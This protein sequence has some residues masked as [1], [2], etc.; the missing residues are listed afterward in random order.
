M[1]LLS[2]TIQGTAPLLCN[3]FH[4]AAQMSATGDSSRISTIGDRGTPLDQAQLKLYLSESGDPHIP[5]PNVFR[6]LIEAGKFFKSGKSKLTT[7]K[8]SLIPACVNILDIEIPLQHKQPWTVD[9]R[10]VRIP[11]TGGRILA[12]RPCFHDWTL[13]FTIELDVDLM[14]LKLLRDVVDA[15][16]KRVGLGDF[17]PDCKGPFGRFVV[18]SWQ[19]LKDG[20][21]PEVKVA[22]AA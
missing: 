12:H 19:E 9:T 7:Q 11:S 17:R 14:S 4:D 21:E 3:K 22:E 18:T 16:G 2:V 10:P 8:N 13:T 5:G 15:A 20:V 1:K 6:M